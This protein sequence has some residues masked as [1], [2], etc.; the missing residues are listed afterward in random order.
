M[1]LRV[2]KALNYMIIRLRGNKEYGIYMNFT[3]AADDTI[4]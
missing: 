4:I 3:L 1:I 2:I